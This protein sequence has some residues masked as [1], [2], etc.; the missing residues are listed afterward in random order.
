MALVFTMCLG[1][2]TNNSLQAEHGLSFGRQGTSP[3]VPS[4]CSRRTTVQVLQAELMKWVVFF[5]G[6]PML[7]LCAV[8]WNSQD[9]LFIF[10]AHIIIAIASPQ[11]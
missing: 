11:M 1:G 3:L 10:Q 8:R 4:V 5:I 2:M 7:D 9:Y 6:R